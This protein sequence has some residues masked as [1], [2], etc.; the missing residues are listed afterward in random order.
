MNLVARAHPHRR[1]LFVLLALLL[2]A[3]VGAALT[4]A[5][6][7]YPSVAFRRIVVLAERGETAVRGMLVSVTR[8]IEQAVATV[9]DLLRVRS[10][11]VRGACEFSLHFRPQADLRD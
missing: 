9:P 11:T 2:A 1:A 8:P 7:I 6:S 4:V 5:R 10:R 3:G